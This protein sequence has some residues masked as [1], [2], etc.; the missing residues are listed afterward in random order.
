MAALDYLEFPAQGE[1]VLPVS[2][3][4][5]AQFNDTDW[6]L[7]VLRQAGVDEPADIAS[8]LAGLTRRL[9]RGRCAVVF[10]TLDTQYPPLKQAEE[11]ARMEGEWLRDNQAVIRRNV[12]GVAFL[13]TNPAVRFILS[14]V[15]LVASLPVPHTVTGDP[16]EARNYCLRKLRTPSLRP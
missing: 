4:M 16:S 1:R 14:S 10:D 7:L 3:P 15:L 13:L 12:V 6:P 9:S 11:Y 2:E 8:M 5:P